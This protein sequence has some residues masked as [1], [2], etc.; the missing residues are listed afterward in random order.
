[1][2]L[3]SVTIRQ[4]KLP[5]CS[6]AAL[7]GVA[8]MIINAPI[9]I[10][11]TPPPQLTHQPPLAS[12]PK[13]NLVPRPIGP[14]ILITADVIKQANLSGTVTLDLLSHLGAATITGSSAVTAEM[15]SGSGPRRFKIVPNVTNGGNGQVTSD[16]P[17]DI[18]PA[19]LT[20]I[21]GQGITA[22]TKFTG[23]PTAPDPRHYVATSTDYVN[24]TGWPTGTILPLPDPST[25]RSS[26]PMLSYNPQTMYGAF[27]LRLYC[28]GTSY[29]NPYTNSALTVWYTDGDGSQPWT[30]LIVDT[31]TNP[32][33]IDKPSI[34]TSRGYYTSGYTYVAAVL[35]DMSAHTNTLH[36]YVQTNTLG[37]QLENNQFSLPEL[38]LQ[39]P[40]VLTDDF[41]FDNVYVVWADWQNMRINIATS[42]NGG[43]NFGTPAV[44]PTGIL[45]NGANTLNGNVRAASVIMARYNQYDRSIGVVWHQ[46]ESSTARTDVFFASYSITSGSWGPIRHVGHQPQN[47]GFDQ[48]NPAL[49]PAPDG[50]YLVT[51]YD[52]R[53]DP[54][55][56]L[57]RVYANHINS[58]GTPYDGS[59]DL[60]VYNPDLLNGPAADPS[61]LPLIGGV[62]YMGEYQDVYQTNTFYSGNTWYGSTVYNPSNGT[63]D[64]YFTRVV[65]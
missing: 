40:I 59:D 13:P 43:Y 22:F 26:D 29:Q 10:A 11:T 12:I 15:V 57:Y 31:A 50:T 64:I 54:N 36:V 51:W 55:D 23:N 45:F 9:A 27:P 2:K 19:V 38:Q 48:W 16:T 14:P 3:L 65:P 17:Q 63:Q 39:S 58:D 25:T 28:V 46:R 18:E 60:L 34:N 30:P 53:N 7:V 56:N 4:Q 62:H 24:F 1:M 42:T 8:A 6:T 35:N 61:Q 32:V 52:R 37:F 44:L 49:D 20:T 41:S 21:N 33:L 5:F 47:D